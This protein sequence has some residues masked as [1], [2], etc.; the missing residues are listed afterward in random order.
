MSTY[1]FSALG[2]FFLIMTALIEFVEGWNTYQLAGVYAVSLFFVIG[3][4]ALEGIWALDVSNNVIV[5]TINGIVLWRFKKSDAHI[6]KNIPWSDIKITLTNRP[7][8]S[9]GDNYVVYNLKTNERVDLWRYWRNASLLLRGIL[10]YAP[11][12]EPDEFRIIHKANG[13]KGV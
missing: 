4:P 11:K 6:S 2:S 9:G 12:S 7:R 8:Y 13:I 10:R 1:G 5:V 3:V